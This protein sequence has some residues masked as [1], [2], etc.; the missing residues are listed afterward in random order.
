MNGVSKSVDLNYA[1]KRV[2]TESQFCVQT[3]E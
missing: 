3:E 1:T 2:H